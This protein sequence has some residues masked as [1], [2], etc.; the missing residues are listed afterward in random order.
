[1]INVISHRGYW[2]QPHEKN[3]PDAFRRSF[4]LGYGTETDI[5]DSVCAG[6]KRLVISHDI[7]SGEE[8]FFE[9][10]LGI[11][12][13]HGKP[14][15]A[16]NIKSDGLQD[17]I[18]EILAAHEYSNYFLFDASVPDLIQAEKK[19]LKCY[20]R[21]SEYETVPS[22]YDA[23]NV[24]GVWVDA[25]QSG[26]WYDEAVVERLLSDGKEVALVAPDLHKRL[27][28]FVPYFEWL[29][30]SGLSQRNGLI[31][32]TDEPE[33]ATQILQG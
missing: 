25:F 23:P 27:D 26:R 12:C 13:E 11:A 33:R 7:P 19:G 2:K 18:Q 28:E 31:V 32:C 29:K 20:T 10:M 15:L 1:M 16:L 21:L 9:N 22:L 5:R 17:L 14:L 8:M 3:T 24:V 6:E 30:V 4:S